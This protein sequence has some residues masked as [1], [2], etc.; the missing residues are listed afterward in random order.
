MHLTLKRGS[1]S[2]FCVQKIEIMKKVFFLAVAAIV[3]IV[4][5]YLLFFKE[6]NFKAKNGYLNNINS[7]NVIIE[8][9]DPIFL[10]Y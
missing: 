9:Y 10:L 4:G 5:A 3:T 2:F 1:M 7:K 8:G 6:P